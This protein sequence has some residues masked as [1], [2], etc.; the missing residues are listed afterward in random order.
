MAVL[1]TGTDL[2]RCSIAGCDGMHEARG[3]CGKH[4][5][6]WRHTGDPL[7]PDRRGKHMAGRCREQNPAWKGD[8]IGYLSLHKRLERER[9]SASA[10]SC[11]ACGEQARDWAFDEP[12]GWS[13]DLSRYSPMCRP[14]HAEKDK[15]WLR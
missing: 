7:A 9:G 2:R 3:W 10:L 6:R 13:T 14:C 5:Q 1:A 12:R 15:P 11:V 8:D 4:Y